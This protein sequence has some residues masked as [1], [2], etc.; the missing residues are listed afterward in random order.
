MVQNIA[1]SQLEADLLLHKFEDQFEQLS[2]PY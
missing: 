1:V 2:K